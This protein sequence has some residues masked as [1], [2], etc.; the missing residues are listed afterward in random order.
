[1]G[2]QTNVMPVVMGMGDILITGN[3]WNE[4][5]CHCVLFS[6]NNFQGIKIE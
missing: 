1:M 2:E 3:D 5:R 6:R 4:Q